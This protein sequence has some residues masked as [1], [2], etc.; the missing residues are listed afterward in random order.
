MIK[1]VSAETKDARHLLLRFSNGSWGVHDFGRYVDAAT[2]MTLPLS[3]PA[4][5][6]RHFIEAGALAW[7]NGFDLSAHALHERLQQFNG[8]HR[9]AETACGRYS[10]RPD[11]TP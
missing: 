9:D 3:D 4:F 8:L 11:F 7:P 5:F 1:L 2:E 6:S 10:Q